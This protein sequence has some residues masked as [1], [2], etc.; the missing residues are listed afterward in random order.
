MRRSSA[1]AGRQTGG[2]KIVSQL[3][4]ETP[5]KGVKSVK[6]V[7]G[8]DAVKTVKSVK[9]VKDPVPGGQIG[10]LLV[11]LCV[12]TGVLRAV[13]SGGADATH[14][15]SRYQVILDHAPFGQMGTSADNAPEPGFATR[16]TFVGITS[17]GDDKPLV[18]VIQENDTKHVDFKAEGESIERV[19]VVKIEKSE[20]GPSKL[21]LKQDLETATLTMEAKSGAGAAAPGPGQPGSPGQPQQPGGIPGVRRIPFR[22]GG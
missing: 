21:V 16:F 22:R 19:M 4:G 6:T 17:E 5:V 18:A 20:T 1:G 14:D 8:V 11:I 12:V 13:P 15:F 2:G 10:R 3:T 7:K 9:T